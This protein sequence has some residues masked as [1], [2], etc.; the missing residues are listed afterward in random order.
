M[1]VDVVGISILMWEGSRILLSPDG[2]KDKDQ[3]C[4]F[5]AQDIKL[6][7]TEDTECHK[8]RV[9]RQRKALHCPNGYVYEHKRIETYLSAI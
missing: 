3:G 7:L 6:Y 1:L 2:R 4:G 5:L 8:A 9:K